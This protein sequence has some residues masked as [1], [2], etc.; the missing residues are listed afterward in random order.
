MTLLRTIDH[1]KEYTIWWWLSLDTVKIT[2]AKS[3]GCRTKTWMTKETKNKKW[4]IMNK[5]LKNC[6]LKQI[7]TWAFNQCHRILTTKLHRHWTTVRALTTEAAKFTTLLMVNQTS[8]HMQKSQ[9]FSIS[10]CVTERRESL[11][12]E[13]WKEVEWTGMPTTRPHGNKIII[14]SSGRMEYSLI[15]TTQLTVSA[16]LKYLKPDKQYINCSIF[17]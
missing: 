10:K 13:I 11:K 5:S 15:Y 2:W 4:R 9:V 8:T 6:K 16:K 12:L 3:N 14:F 7:T 1:S 17:T